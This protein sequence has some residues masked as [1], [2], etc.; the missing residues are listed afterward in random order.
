MK[1][2]ELDG[3]CSMYAGDEGAAVQLSD[4]QELC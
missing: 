1:E 2:D 3:K 4:S